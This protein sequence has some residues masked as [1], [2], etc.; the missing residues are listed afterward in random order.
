M[1]SINIVVSRQHWKKRIIFIFSIY[2]KTPGVTSSI[3]DQWMKRWR[4]TIFLNSLYRRIEKQPKFLPGENR[5][6]SGHPT[7]RIM[8]ACLTP[9]VENLVT[10][11]DTDQECFDR[12]S[13]CVVQAVDFDWH[14]QSDGRHFFKMSKKK[15]I[16]FYFSSSCLCVFFFLVWHIVRFVG[17]LNRDYY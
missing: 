16:F 6:E 11:I 17:L 14:G 1:N 8:M 9:I 3:A 4:E 15:G 12:H 2:T 5:E 13:S 10:C 7:A